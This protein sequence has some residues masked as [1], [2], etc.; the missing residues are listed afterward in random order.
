MPIT[1]MP[2]TLKSPPAFVAPAPE[3]VYLSAG[4]AKIALERL[5]RRLPSTEFIDAKASQ[6]CGMV[7]VRM[8]SGRTAYTDPTGR[9]FLLAFAM[10]TH[11]GSPADNAEAIETA[12]EAR[13]TFPTQTIPGI[14]PQDYR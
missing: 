2:P 9:Y 3:C 7:V 13:A 11:M 14:F 8:A 10:D 1:D 4:D 6:V 12:T 5:Q